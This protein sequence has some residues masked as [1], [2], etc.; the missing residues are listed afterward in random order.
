MNLEDERYGPGISSGIVLSITS[1]DRAPRYLA[2]KPRRPLGCTD[3]EDAPTSIL[4]NSQGLTSPDFTQEHVKNPSSGLVSGF[5]GRSQPGSSNYL[6]SSLMPLKSGISQQK[7]CAVDQAK[8]AKISRGLLLLRPGK[9][10]RDDFKQLILHKGWRMADVACRWSIR[11]E[12]MSRIAA[13]EDRDFK[14]DDLAR[15]LPTLSPNEQAAVK[16]AR[17]VLA[18][19]AKRQRKITQVQDAPIEVPVAVASSA[20]ADKPFTWNHDDDEDDEEFA[21]VATDG[22]RWRRYLSRGAELV[23]DSEI[24]NFATFGSILVVVATREGV[25]SA[26]GV[27]EEYQCEAPSGSQRWFEPDEIDDWL[28]YNGKTRDLR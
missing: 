9:L 27:Q 21:G 20:A 17:M 6:I 22:Y 1:E 4:I 13:D 3:P 11:P 18:P 10:S 25:D 5:N 24:D 15:A 2:H 16:A 14:W 12:H 19:P 23:V 28:V 7:T 26:G 8:N